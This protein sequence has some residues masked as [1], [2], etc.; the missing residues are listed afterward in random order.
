[1]SSFTYRVIFKG[2]TDPGKDIASVKQALAGLFKTDAGAV[3]KLF[4]GQPVVIKKDID[5][6]TA[7]QYQAALKK[8]GAH[9]EVELDY[10]TSLEVVH[11]DAPKEIVMMACPKCGFEQ[12]KALTCFRCGIAIE[13]YQKRVE[14][15]EAKKPRPADEEKPD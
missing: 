6:D 3:E 11:N 8:I 7:N 13:K 2:K 4:S 1:M 15:Q 10:D 14:E 9:C 5:Q 12:E